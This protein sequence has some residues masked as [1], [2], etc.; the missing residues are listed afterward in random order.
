MICDPACGSGSLLVKTA[1]HIRQHTGS[2]DYS[3]F[4][5]ELNRRNWALAKLNMFLHGEQNQ[6]LELGDTYHAPGEAALRDAGPG[7]GA[8]IQENEKR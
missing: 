2:D 4:G 3:L 1:A 8:G 6:R 7:F 5:R